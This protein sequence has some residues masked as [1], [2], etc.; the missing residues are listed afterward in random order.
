MV[1]DVGTDNASLREAD[2]LYL[3][4]PQ[5]RVRGEA[6]Y[7]LMQVGAWQV[8]GSRKG[9]PCATTARGVTTSQPSTGRCTP[10]AADRSLR[11]ASPAACRSL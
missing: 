4:L 3:G 7:A 11:R 1:V 10:R 2:P 8:A 6:Y 9:Q 5:R